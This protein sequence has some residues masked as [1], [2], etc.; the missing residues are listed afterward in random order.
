MFTTLKSPNVPTPVLLEQRC[1]YGKLLGKLSAVAANKR[2]RRIA[3]DSLLPRIYVTPIF[4]IVTVTGSKL[5]KPIYL[6]GMGILTPLLMVDFLWDIRLSFEM[7]MILTI[8]QKSPETLT[9][10]TTIDT[11]DSKTTYIIYGSH[12]ITYP[13]GTGKTPVLSA[14][15]AL[16]VLLTHKPRGNIRGRNRRSHSYY[17]AFHSSSPFNSSLLHLFS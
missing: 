14:L 1:S 6:Q 11:V 13:T 8:S 7:V 3:A 15:V 4:A 9:I 17:H 2:T 16:N 12:R 10:M 5:P